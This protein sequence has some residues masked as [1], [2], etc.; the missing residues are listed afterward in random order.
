VPF[1]RDDAGDRTEHHAEDIDL[2]VTMTLHEVDAGAELALGDLRAR[3]MLGDQPEV[4]D[5][6]SRRICVLVIDLPA[7]P[8][9][10]GA[11]R[12]SQPP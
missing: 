8:D 11:G 10:V 6:L 1:G 3:E 9:V 12:V 5:I 4:L 7:D 2:R